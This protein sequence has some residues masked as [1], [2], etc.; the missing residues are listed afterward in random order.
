MAV[1]V[2]TR[3]LSARE[4]QSIYNALVQHVQRTRPDLWTD[5]FQANLGITLVELLATVGDWASFGQDAALLETFMATCRRYESGLA[6]SR[7]IGYA[8]LQASAAIASVYAPIP[9]STSLLAYGGVLPAG[10]IV[11]GD[12]GLAYEFI[13]DVL[14][15]PGVSSVRAQVVQGTSYV[16]TFSLG[17]TANPQATT[18]Y[19]SVAQASW[20]VFVGDPN[21]PDNRWTQVSSVALQPTPSQ[22]YEVLFD[23]SSRLTVR[24]GDGTYGA[25]PTQ[26]VT[27]KYRVCDGAAG[28]T[29]VQTIRGTVQVQLNSPGTGVT[30]L[31]FENYDALPATEGNVATQS[32]EAGTPLA[33]GAGSFAIVQSLAHVPVTPGSVRMT[34]TFS[35]GGGYI[36]LQDDA[37]GNLVVSGSAVTITDLGNPPTNVIGILNAYINYSTGAIAI[38][39]TDDLPVPNAG[40]I[41]V[42][43]YSYYTSVDPSASLVQGSATGGADRQDLEQL[44]LAVRAFMK[45]QDRLITVDDY[46]QGLLNVPGVSLAKTDTRPLAFIGNIIRLS[47]WSS[48]HLT[49]RSVVYDG[50]A[51]SSVYRRYAIASPAVAADIRSYVQDKSLVATHNVVQRPG[52][53]W[54]DLYFQDLYYDPRSDAQAVRDGVTQAVT[55]LFQNASGFAIRLSELYAAIYAVSGVSYF[56]LQRIALGTRSQTTT[57]DDLGSTT[58]STTFSSS[59]PYVGS[60]A[61][62]AVLKPGSL[63]IS[64][65]QG[66]DRLIIADNSLGGLVLLAGSSNTLAGSGNSI[67]YITGVLQLAFN[68]VLSAGNPVLATYDNVTADYRQNPQLTKDSLDDGDAWPSP[69]ASAAQTTPADTSVKRYDGKPLT[70]PGAVNIQYDSLKDILIEPALADYRFYDD[71]YPYDNSF[72]YNSEIRFNQDIRAIDLRVLDFRVVPRQ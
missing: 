68:S 54:V 18:T 50:L 8:P 9:P 7:S 45:S 70:A 21:N 69:S 23:A 62:G 59:L 46:D 10:S 27:V 1:T 2:P 67:D 14:I 42:S 49:F 24:F 5:F 26:V 48:E 55:T 60:V 28:N 66:A 34:L 11:S 3:T 56:T 61:N 64:I 57:P 37:Y 47:V 17:V 39:L 53:L 20:Q 44:R 65:V 6:F 72:Y 36:V 12:N 31:T 43:D 30:A 41:P 63:R 38:S 40:G 25:I 52:I 29:P 13:S 15:A 32:S 58:A 51:G 33:G 71:S 19:G 4:F 22:T 16:E 35:S